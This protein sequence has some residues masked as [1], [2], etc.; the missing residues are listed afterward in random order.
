MATYKS[1]KTKISYPAETVFAKLSHLEGLSDVLQKVPADSLSSEHRAMLEQIKV[2]SDTITFPGGPVGDVTLGVV[3]RVEPSL[4]K[5]EGVGTP[6]P[7]SLTLHVKPL[8]SE[9]C[10]AYVEL[11]VQIPMM[12]KPMVNKPLQDMAD[13][14]G[15]M[16]SQI[17]YA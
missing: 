5:L 2:T 14:F 10:E 8:T 15:K 16:L 6:V 3:E 12:L 1:D 9:S 4:I 11:E 17:P 7:M 13:Q